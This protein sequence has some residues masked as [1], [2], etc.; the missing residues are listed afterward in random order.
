MNAQQLEMLKKLQEEQ[1][2]C[3]RMAVFWFDTDPIWAAFWQREGARAF[4][5]IQSNTEAFERRNA[6]LAE[7]EKRERCEAIATKTRR[8]YR[9]KY[10]HRIVSVVS[11]GERGAVL[12]TA[13]NGKQC[14]VTAA[15]MVAYHNR[16]VLPHVGQDIRDIVEIVKAHRA[17]VAYDVYQG[18][19]QAMRALSAVCPVNAETFPHERAFGC[20]LCCAMQTARNMAKEQKPGVMFATAGN[21]F[22]SANIGESLELKSAFVQTYFDALKRAYPSGVPVHVSQGEIT[23]ENN[24]MAVRII[25]VGLIA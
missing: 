14:T 9:G 12:V 19:G 2:H 13:N 4:A 17:G 10:P 1:A 25:G 5:D 8:A 21:A 18:F 7:I 3:H 6:E 24:P 11:T 16:P 22:V 20:F 15:A 23:E